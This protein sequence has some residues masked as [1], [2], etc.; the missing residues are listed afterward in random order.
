MVVFV[1]VVQIFIYIYDSSSSTKFF[2]KISY[3][4]LFTIELGLFL[5]YYSKTINW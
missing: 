1:F 5:C 2:S 4:D 3:L